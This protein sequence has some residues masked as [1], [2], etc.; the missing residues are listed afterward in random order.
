M[1][2]IEYLSYHLKPICY[3]DN[4]KAAEE[5]LKILKK[6]NPEAKIQIERISPLSTVEDFKFEGFENIKLFDSTPN[7]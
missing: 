7:P 2:K 3:F 4:L 1:Y 5:S 6:K